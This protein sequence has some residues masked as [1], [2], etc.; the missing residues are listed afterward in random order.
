MPYTTRAEMIERFGERELIQLT[1]RSG[2]GIIDEAVLSRAMADADAEIDGYLRE[3][4][5]LPLAAVPPVLARL[6]ANIARYN[7]YDEMAPEEPRRRYEDA[8]R[9]LKAIAKGE[10]HLG[11]PTGGAAPAVG[12]PKVAGPART[13]SR[14]GLRSY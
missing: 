6:A 9:T 5:A 1:D 12:A 14:N 13:F 10:V 3:R 2:A 4:Y 8:V 7:L 11:L